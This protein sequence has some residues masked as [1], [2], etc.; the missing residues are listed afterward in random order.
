[1]SWKPAATFPKVILRLIVDGFQHWSFGLQANLRIPKNNLSCIV[2]SFLD[3]KNMRW[4]T[5]KL[6]D[7]IFSGKTLVLKSW[8]FSKRNWWRLVWTKHWVSKWSS[9]H[10]S[11]I[12][13]RWG[14]SFRETS[15]I[16]DLR[17]KSSWNTHLALLSISLTGA[18]NSKSK[19]C[20]HNPGVWCD[21]STWSCR[22]KLILTSSFLHQEMG[23]DCSAI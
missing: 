3:T 8:A 10:W 19:F 7:W 9:A 20:A 21:P 13:L 4:V 12:F 5:H 14:M 11:F 1:M 17:F 16:Q 18:K 22:G 15:K 2:L 23:W 6:K